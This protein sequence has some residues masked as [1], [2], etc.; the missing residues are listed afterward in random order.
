[1]TQLYCVHLFTVRS[2]HHGPGWVELLGSAKGTPSFP[3]VEHPDSFMQYT[4]FV[5]CPHVRQ[6][7]PWLNVVRA[8]DGV[9]CWCL[10]LVVLVTWEAEMG[11][12]WLRPA[13][14]NSYRDPHLQNN[15][16]KMDWGCDSNSRAPAL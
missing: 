7:L 10:T 14:A 16:S 5:A 13:W 3:S 9:V 1:M 15:Q 6:K 8:T 11:G 2:F 12:L 4:W